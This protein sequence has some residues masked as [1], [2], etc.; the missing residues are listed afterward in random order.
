MGQLIYSGIMSLDGYTADAAGGFDWAVPDPAV[1]AAINELQRGIGTQLYGRR[2]YEVM[3]AWETVPGPADPESLPA[4][5]DDAVMADFAVVWR[6]AEKIVY[7]RTLPAVHTTR[8]RLE[9]RF[10]TDAVARLKSATPHDLSVSGPHL[11]A[12]ALTA[13]LVDEYQLVVTP[14]LVGGGTAFF[15][16]GV[17]LPLTLVEERRFDSGTVLLRYRT[18]GAARP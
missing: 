13:G 10:D 4:G 17:T 7:S 9:R 2:M 14:V 15:P 8:T 3:S 6:G 18:S 5:L 1:H 16:P 11:A 12:Q